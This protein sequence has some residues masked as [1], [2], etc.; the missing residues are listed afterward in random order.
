MDFYFLSPTEYNETKWYSG[1][2]PNPISILRFEADIFMVF[3]LL[4]KIKHAA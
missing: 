1:D 4:D 2:Q 3:S